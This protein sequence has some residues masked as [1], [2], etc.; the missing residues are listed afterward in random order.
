MEQR[1]GEGQRRRGRTATGR[2][3][4]KRRRSG[5]D[6]GE[7]NSSD[8]AAEEKDTHARDDELKAMMEVEGFDIMTTPCGPDGVCA[9]DFALGENGEEHDALAVKRALAALGVDVNATNPGGE[10]ALW[11]QCLRGRS[12]NVKLLCVVR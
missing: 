7:G 10:T 5:K 4:V 9:L 11:F 1:A 2:G 12:R 6:A 8:D 3:Q